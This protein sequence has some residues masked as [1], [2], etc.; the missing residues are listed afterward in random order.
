MKGKTT[1][2]E[3][4]WFFVIAGSLLALAE[5]FAAG[6]ISAFIDAIVAAVG[7]LVIA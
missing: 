6:T 4:E 5:F 1:P 7:A 3:W 2:K